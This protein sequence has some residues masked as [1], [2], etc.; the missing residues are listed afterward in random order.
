MKYAKYILI[1]VALYFGIKYHNI[2]LNTEKEINSIEDS[3]KNEMEKKWKAYSLNSENISFQCDSA[4]L[5][6]DLKYLILKHDIEIQYLQGKID[7]QTYHAKLKESDKSESQDNSVN[8]EAWIT[9]DES[10]PLPETPI[11]NLLYEKR[12]SSDG[13]SSALFVLF[14]I[15]LPLFLLMDISAW[16]KVR[17]QHQK[18]IQHPTS[19]MEQM[20][21]N[22]QTLTRLTGNDGK[23]EKNEVWE[24]QN[25]QYVKVPNTY[26]EVWEKANNQKN[27]NTMEYDVDG[28]KVILERQQAVDENGEIIADEWIDENG[29]PVDVPAEVTAAW[30]RLKHD[31]Q[32]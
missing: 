23:G 15:I 4:G 24:D 16:Q 28:K 6:L 31:V 21:Y 32:T 13:N 5:I 29:M 27:D 18:P 1:V 8:I 2:Y 7:D 22:G 19:L 3:Y 26:V 17:R 20:I 25:G 9:K 11:P 30:D 12:N 10:N 14:G